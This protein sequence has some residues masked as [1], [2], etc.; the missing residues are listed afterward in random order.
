MIG[1]HAEVAVGESD[2]E[3]QR[4]GLVARGRRGE[5]E[6]TP[7][8]RPH[9]E[10]H[11]AVLPG[12]IRISGIRPSHEYDGLMGG[13][14]DG[15]DLGVPVARPRPVGVLG[16]GQHDAREQPPPRLPR[17]GGFHGPLVAGEKADGLD[18]RAAEGAVVGIADAELTM[19]AREFAQV[20]QEAVELVGLRDEA[21]QRAEEPVVLPGEVALEVLAITRVRGQE[22]LVERGGETYAIGLDDREALPDRAMS[23]PRSIAVPAVGVGRS[24]GRFTRTS[25]TALNR[26]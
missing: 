9:T 4:F 25:L 2:V 16:L 14:V 10:F 15:G 20:R 19:V 13:V 7:D 24:D 1:G 22:P 12:A 8:V 18:Q 3:L 6:I 11:R 26:G 5:G 21:A 17:R 23:S